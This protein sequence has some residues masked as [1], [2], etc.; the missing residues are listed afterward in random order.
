[1]KNLHRSIRI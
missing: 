1:V